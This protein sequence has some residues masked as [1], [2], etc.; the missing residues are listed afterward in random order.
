[1]EAHLLLVPMTEMFQMPSLS[2]WRFRMQFWARDVLIRCNMT[3]SIWVWVSTILSAR[4]VQVTDNSD[5]L[6]PT[7]AVLAK[8]QKAKADSAIIWAV[9][10]GEDEHLCLH[11][12]LL[13][14]NTESL[15]GKPALRG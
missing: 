9:V 15:S 4:E 3:T 13:P 6:V 10:I 5:Q 11:T 12:Q 2:A 1:M 14:T 7:E 8:I